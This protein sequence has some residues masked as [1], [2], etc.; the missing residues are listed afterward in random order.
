MPPQTDARR[1]EW[2]LYHFLIN[3]SEQGSSVPFTIEYHEREYT[4]YVIPSTGAEQVVGGEIWAQ[5][6]GAKL[7]AHQF[8]ISQG[9]LGKR[10]YNW[11]AKRVKWGD[12]YAEN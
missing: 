12:Q 3:L 4:G 7:Q 1:W 8:N 2:L 11:M 9:S 5:F 10:S 6:M